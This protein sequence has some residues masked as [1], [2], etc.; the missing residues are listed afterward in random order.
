[1]KR[2]AHTALRRLLAAA[3]M[4]CSL[5]LGVFFGFSAGTETVSAAPVETVNITGAQI[6][7]GSVLVRVSA[8]AVPGTDDG[9]YYLYAQDMNQAAAPGTPLLPE[10]AGTQVATAPAAAYAQFGFP[11]NKNLVNSNLCRKFIVAVKQGGVMYTVS[12]SEEYISN[13]EAAAA[14]AA[15]RNY[16]GKKG[17]LPS[18]A[19]LDSG[20]LKALGVHQIT[21][22]VPIGNLCAAGGAMIPFQYNGKI[23]H[24]NQAIVG[25]YDKLV[26][27][28]NG[29]G[30]E[31]TLILLNNRTGDPTLIH[32]LSRAYGGANYYAL[33][34]LETA[35]I[36]KLQAV[37]AF[38]GQRYS[39]TGHGTVDNWIIGNEVNAYSIWHYMNADMATFIS[40]Y[41]KAF[42]I[43][44]NVLKTENA[45]ARVYTC[46]DQQW[47]RAYAGGHY[48]SVNFLN[49]F[50]ALISSTGNID[51]RLAYHPYNYPMTNALAW[52][53][54]A[55]IVH[56][57]DTPFVSMQNIDVVTDY[58][59]QPAF[60][61]PSGAVRSVLLS[62]QGY[63]S[64]AGEQLQAASVVYGYLQAMANSHV[65]GFILAREQ[66]DGGEIA[67]G[68]ANGLT[69]LGGG[70]KLA[71]EYYQHIDKAD[72][73]TYI[74]MANNIAGVN[75]QSLITPR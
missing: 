74:S 28:M 45:N 64:L 58:L 48:S 40:E 39:G 47:N 38:L 70:H 46:L 11:L 7:G 27:Q 6:S 59:S 18:A 2:T 44:Y 19:L 17:I 41:A 8:S 54:G 71:W 22:N 68:L 30:I 63:T 75:L 43:F 21:Y 29:Y 42:R 73:G 15:V 14:R 25:Q 36:E 67:T 60:R 16:S 32:P 35:G 49:S 65:D 33:N 20:D 56:S 13:P 62:E 53:P 23:Y 51:W 26:P 50:N 66:D 55:S 52:A 34:T 12:S 69:G 4:I 72:A 31:V 24:F 5:S 3:G 9:L 10:N 61:S 37:A 57:A 1:M